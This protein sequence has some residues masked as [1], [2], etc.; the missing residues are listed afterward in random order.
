MRWLFFVALLSVPTSAIAAEVVFPGYT[1]QAAGDGIF[2][3]SQVDPLSGPVDG[4]SVV[5]LNE[6][7]VMVVDTHIN[8]AVARAVVAKIQSLTDVPVTHVIN[9]H[10]HD[11]HTNGNYVYRQA[12]PGVKIIAHRA[13]LKSLQEEWAPMEDQR[14]TAY[15][16]VDLEELQ[17]IA[18][19]PET[20]DPDTA[21]SYGLYAGYV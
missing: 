1:W 9:T 13:T 3:H 21:I 18:S 11:D 8:P 5:I 10:W 14:R 7:G 19:D 16:G 6:D 20:S 17:R 15:A 4:N 12:F 2:L